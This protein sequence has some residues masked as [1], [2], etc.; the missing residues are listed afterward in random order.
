[1][2]N[3][4]QFKNNFKGGARPSLFEVQLNFPLATPNASRAAQVSRFMVKGATLPGSVLGLIEVPYRGR[5]LKIAG[6]RTFEPMTLT[7]INDVGMEIRNAFEEWMNIISRHTS[8]TTG[9]AP[10]AYYRDMQIR[11][12]D[13]NGAFIKQC[14]VVDAY[15]TNISAIE[16]SFETN[17]AVEDFTVEFNY[18]HWTSDTTVG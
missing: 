3:L 9:F 6:D 4:S 15:P 13:V 17:D 5:K 16:L 8:N 18:Q 11:Q 14:N 1:M 10:L 2:S 7:V 12:I